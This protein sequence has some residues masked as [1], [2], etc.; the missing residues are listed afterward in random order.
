MIKV[1]LRLMALVIIILLSSCAS[2]KNI[3]YFQNDSSQ[4]HIIEDSYA[5]KFKNDDLLAINVSSK[6]IETV[7]AYT[8]PVVSYN[9]NGSAANGIPKQQGYLIDVQGNIEFPGLGTLHLAGLTRIQAINLLKRKLKASVTDVQVNIEILNFNINVLGDVRKPGAYKI[10]NERVTLIDALALAGDTNI[11]GERIIEVK[12][13]T[14]NGLVTGLVDLKSNTIFSSPFY[15]LQQNDLVYV[16]PN[17]AKIQSAASN[18]NTG[19]YISITSI[20]ISLIS[21]LTR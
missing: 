11:S 15:Y 2:K 5:L 7:K 6:D 8:L 10:S 19:L 9:A 18:Q 17:Y 1:F 20:L 12:R 4:I 21:V 3:L 16:R 14:P 13:E